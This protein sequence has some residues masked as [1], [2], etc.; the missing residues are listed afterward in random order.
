MRIPLDYYRILGLPVQA[1]HEQLQQAYLDRT[2]QLPRR[3]YS[4]AAVAARKQLLETAYAV[5]SDP[6][7][8]AYYD[9]SYLTHTYSSEAQSP[10]GGKITG[11][12][13]RLAVAVA[14]HTSGIEIPDEQ[15]VG[16]LLIL[17]EL[18]EY[19]LVLQLGRPYL[20]S[21]ISPEAGV[22]NIPAQVQSDIVLTAAL[23]YLELGREQWQQGKYEHAAVSLEAG[24]EL[25]SRAELFPQIQ[26][27][28]QADLCKLRPYRILELLAQP[29]ENVTERRLGL[30]LLEKLLQVRGGIDGT[31]ED[32]SGLSMDDFLRFIQQLRSHLTLAE[33]QNL[34]EPY[35][36]SSAVTAYLVVYGLIAQGFAQ[37]LPASIA[38]AKL[39]LLRLGKHQDLHLEQAV[40]ALLL[41]QT[42]QANNAIELSHEYETLAFIREHSQGSPDL[43]PGLCLYSERWL[44]TEVFPHFRDLAQ[45]QA[46]LKD[47]FADEQVQSYLE[48]LPIETETTLTASS[49]ISSSES[50]LLSQS[51]HRSLKQQTREKAKDIQPP[52]QPR[53]A[54]AIL[55]VNP[56]DAVVPAAARSS[57]EANSLDNNHRPQSSKRR[58]RSDSSQRRTTGEAFR[59]WGKIR[60]ISSR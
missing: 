15:L 42:Q 5:L 7:Q 17:Q 46:S 21:S 30:Q 38:R 53:S 29:E 35:Q 41:G 10:T 3:E 24:Q 13:E 12:S 4:E 45:Q 11:H 47:Y 8:R 18:G 28:I 33:Q 59:R 23:A 44:Q 16:A 54:T 58:R 49:A 2:V 26:A 27:E 6:K 52:S 9:T 25:L 40:C 31:G 37:R 57:R 20:I 60:P 22:R 14:P 36:R 34:F 51:S 50:E 1:S 39:L 55:N 56:P 19:E 32:G 48:A 43:L